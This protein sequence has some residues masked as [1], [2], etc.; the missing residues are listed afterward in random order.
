MNAV[1]HILRDLK[2]LHQSDDTTR[3]GIH[4]FVSAFGSPV[5]AIAYGKLFWPD[6]VEVEGMVFLASM[7]EDESDEQRVREALGQCIANRA[8]VQKSFNL[9]EVPSGIFGKRACESSNEV[10]EE[11]ARLIGTTWKCRLA[12]EYPDRSFVVEVSCELN[13]EPTVSFHELTDLK[14]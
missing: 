3:F 8:E 1:D 9:L 7:V 5:E 6:F 12:T 4:D 2:K 13:D 10:D 11:L 14:R